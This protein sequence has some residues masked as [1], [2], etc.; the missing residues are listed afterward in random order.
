MNKRNEPTPKHLHKKVLKTLKKDL[1]SGEDT[2]NTTPSH[3]FPS[4]NELLERVPSKKA[5]IQMDHLK[6]MEKSMHRKKAKALTKHSKRTSPD[7]GIV[8]STPAHPHQEG[9]RWIK[10]LNKQTKAK[11]KINDKNSGKI[12]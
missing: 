6:S 4:P 9:A 5:K 7:D 3:E 12:G 8:N 10:T 11:N 1:R 2:L